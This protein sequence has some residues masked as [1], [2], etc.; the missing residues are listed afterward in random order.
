MS[1]TYGLHE[2]DSIFDRLSERYR[3]VGP[4]RFAGQAECT[5]Q[6]YIGYGPIGSTDDLVT[7]R[8]S[9]FSP[10]EVVFPVR[11]TL[12]SFDGGRSHVPTI[13]DRDVILF[14]RSCD[15][16]GIDRL[17]RIFQANGPRSDFYYRRRRARLTFFLLEC[18]ESFDSCFCVSMGTNRTD[19][20]AV[21]LRFTGDTV[22][23]SVNDSS[24]DDVFSTGGTP[25]ESSPRFV[26]K[27]HRQVRV[28]PTEA[29]SVDVFD[30]PL[31]DEYSR[32]CIGCGRCNTSC[33]T[34]SCFTMQDT[35]G[36]QGTRRRRW[37]GCHLDG[38]TDMA[39]GHTYRAKNGERMR[40]KTM[41]KINDY[42]RRFGVHMCVG[43]GRCDDVCP[44]Y[45]S[46]STCINNLGTL[47]TA[48][49]S[50]ESL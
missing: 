43:C 41:H 46:F 8:K 42:H 15:I 50:D 35:G 10:K 33:V 11:E 5:D 1:R 25:C 4:T 20:Y 39:G 19:D 21:A 13:D 47:V 9:W 6:D 48:G 17:D 40:F 45:I 22:Q 49:A 38:F 36:E 44:E 29:L 37:A 31:W 28:P 2:L 26:E 27:N 16:H 7:D 32:R 30:H 18:G 14:L 24:F 12:L 34:C 3:L 23:A